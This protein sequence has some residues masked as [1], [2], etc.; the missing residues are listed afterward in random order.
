MAEAFFEKE[1]TLENVNEKEIVRGMDIPIEK[2]IEIILVLCGQ[3]PTTEMEFSSNSWEE[4]AKEENIDEATINELRKNL[5]QLNLRSYVSP[6]EL[7]ETNIEDRLAG[8]KEPQARKSKHRNV[9]ISKNEH[10]LQE[11]IT[12]MEV[13]DDNAMG[14]L[15]GYPVTTIQAFNNISSEG[16]FR[17]DLPEE[18]RNAEYYPYI[19]FGI[20]S[21]DN[22]QEE[23]NVAKR[24]MDRVKDFDETL[25]N[26]Y[27][28]WARK[29]W[30]YDELHKTNQYSEK[31]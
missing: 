2:K 30:L 13:G 24:W 14:R 16:I 23:V 4:G 21:R 7:I 12:A 3:K 11:M 20:L 19:Q 17:K 10:D 9:I 26:Q 18:V 29:E 22:W 1:I 5:R 28:E 31:V 6:E 25:H 15:F 27:I 8:E